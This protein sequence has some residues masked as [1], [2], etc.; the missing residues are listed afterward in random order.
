MTTEPRVSEDQQPPTL[1][2]C[3][4]APAPE[5]VV[6][7]WKQLLALHTGAQQGFLE[8][9]TTSIVEPGEAALDN[10]L[11]AF[12]EVH[13]LEP[14]PVLRALK[15]C[16]FLLRRSAALDLD[17]Q[18][19]TDDLQKLSPEDPTGA[20]LLA[21]RYL[22]L[23]QRVREHMLDLSLAD[24]GNVLVGLDWRIDHVASTD[25]A[26]NLNAPV[27][28]L[29]LRLRDGETTQRLTV[30]LTNRSLQMLGQ[31]CQRFSA[32]SAAHPA[33]GT[34]ADSGSAA[35]SSIPSAE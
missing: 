14:G 11:A 30:Q 21:S 33:A 22:P 15:A 32:P 29:S 3:H 27:V 4:G 9:L 1:H 19:F 7:D 20:R 16:Q 17:A 34:A 6:H 26:V 18:H 5:G 2:C 35:L 8:L 31:F 24:H 23:K 12:C 13:E 10:D 28:F 25:R